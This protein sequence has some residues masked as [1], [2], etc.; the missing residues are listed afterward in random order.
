MIISS[1]PVP[2]GCDFVATLNSDLPS[3]QP[4]T[5]RGERAPPAQVVL[6][7][8]RGEGMQ[9]R[10][11][12]IKQNGSIFQQITIEN[13]SSQPLSGFALQYNK[14]SYGL[15]PASPAAL[16]QVIPGPIMPGQSATGNMPVVTNGPMAD[17]KGAVQMA[18]KNNVKVF[19][20]QVRHPVVSPLFAHLNPLWTAGRLRSYVLPRGGWPPRQ[21]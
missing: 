19:Y 18:I 14:N 1:S 7:A 21:R 3:V 8:D 16:G 11:L 6:P 4:P 13:H 9:V 20:F 10:S 17:M 2:L 15:V 5:P 12:F